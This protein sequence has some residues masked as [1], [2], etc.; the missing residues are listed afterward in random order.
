VKIKSVSALTCYVSD[1]QKTI[2]FYEMLGFDFKKKDD[3]SAIGY[4]NWFSITFLESDNEEKEEF[5][6]DAKAKEKGMGIFIYL[7]VD[8]VDECYKELIEGGYKP[9]SEPRDWPWGSREFVQKDP[10]GY[11]L[12]FFKKK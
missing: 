8:D 5:Q 3:K 9:S 6:K 2:A 12:V 7:S 1:L 4:M 10:D 11:K